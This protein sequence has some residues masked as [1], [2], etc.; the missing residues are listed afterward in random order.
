M[1]APA[2]TVSVAARD[3]EPVGSGVQRQLVR[4]KLAVVIVDDDRCT[5]DGLSRLVRSFGHECRVAS[6]GDEALRLMGE[7]H[8]DVVIRDWEMPGMSG[9]ELCRRARLVDD[10]ARY[11]YFIL[12]TGFDDREHVMEA[13]DSGADH[14]PAQARRLR[15][16]RGAA[17]AASPACLPGIQRRKDCVYSA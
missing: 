2:I 7:G 12:L 10:E 1:N 9:A 13:M 17:R 8:A 3:A 14:Y 5:G 4:A 16:P 15:R 6:S 11:A